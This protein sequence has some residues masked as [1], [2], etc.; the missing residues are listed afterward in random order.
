[1]VSGQF[2]CHHAEVY[3]LDVDCRHRHHS[4][5]CQFSLIHSKLKVF[6]VVGLLGCGSVAEWLACWTQAQ[7]GLGSNRGS[8]AVG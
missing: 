8:N 5:C 4:R 7:K 3:G 2:F 6:E 1:M